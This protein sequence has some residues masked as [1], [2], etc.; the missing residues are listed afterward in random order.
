MDTSETGF[1]IYT[2]GISKRIGPADEREWTYH[3][4]LIRADY[5]R[6]HPEDSFEA[7]LHRTKFSKEDQ[8][9]LCDWMAVAAQRAE[10]ARREQEAASAPRAAA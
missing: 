9:L 6:C 5:E 7:L 2:N 4:S 8:G 3:A 10:A 1:R